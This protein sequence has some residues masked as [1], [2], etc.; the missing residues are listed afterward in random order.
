[1][2][3]R[4]KLMNT[5]RAQTTSCFLVITVSSRWPSGGLASAR[6]DYTPTCSTLRSQEYAGFVYD[7]L[8]SKGKKKGVLEGRPGRYAQC[9]GGQKSAA[10]RKLISLPGQTECGIDTRRCWISAVRTENLITFDRG[11]NAS[12]G[13]INFADSQT[14]SASWLFAKYL[15]KQARGIEKIP[16]CAGLAELSMVM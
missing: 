13:L 5:A 9:F 8:C 7:G 11:L 12:T 14:K 2:R 1:M 3:T 10:G 4:Y 6:A 16:Q 15:S